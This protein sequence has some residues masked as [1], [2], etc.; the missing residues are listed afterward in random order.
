MTPDLATLIVLANEA[1]NDPAASIDTSFTLAAAANYFVNRTA[2]QDDGRF[3]LG[4]DFI[5]VTGLA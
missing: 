2:H 4:G 1:L 3:F 5:V